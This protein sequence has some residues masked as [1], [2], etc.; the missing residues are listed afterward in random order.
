MLISEHKLD[1]IEDRFIDR[2]ARL[3]ASLIYK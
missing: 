1:G 3:G 2:I